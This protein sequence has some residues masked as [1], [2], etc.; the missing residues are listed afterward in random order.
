MCKVQANYTDKK[1]VSSFFV[2]SHLVF[3]TSSFSSN[4]YINPPKMVADI[5]TGRAPGSSDHQ[6]HPTRL[7]ATDS[8]HTVL[9][10]LEEA[11]AAKSA[12]CELMC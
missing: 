7:W 9:G 5:A 11:A 2:L 8:F 12:G 6:G 4:I 3:L 1:K 10:H